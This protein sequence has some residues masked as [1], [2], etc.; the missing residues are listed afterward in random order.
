MIFAIDYT[1]GKFGCFLGLSPTGHAFPEFDYL[2]EREY[3]AERLE[4]LRGQVFRD[5]LLALIDHLIL[6]Y[7]QI[8]EGGCYYWKC[9]TFSSVWE[10]MVSEYL[11]EYFCGTE[12]ERPVFDRERALHLPFEKRRFYANQA[13][14]EQYVSWMPMPPRRTR[15]I[16]LTRN[17]TP[18]RTGWTISRW[19]I[20]FCCMRGTPAR[21][22][23]WS[24]RERGG[25]AGSIL[26]WRPILTKLAGQCGSG[27]NTWTFGK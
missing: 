22:P 11:K 27:R 8:R 14:L 23:P 6:F 24:S 18:M 12:Q 7:S 20:S 9:D 4:Q 2:G 10:D 3:V 25:R 17:I 21:F 26:R 5:D 19:Y 1:I 13:D 16:F 15:S